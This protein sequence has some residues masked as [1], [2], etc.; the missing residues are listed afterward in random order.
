MLNELGVEVSPRAEFCVIRRAT[1]ATLKRI[2][3][4]EKFPMRFSGRTKVFLVMFRIDQISL[5]SR[6]RFFIETI[7]GFKKMLIFQAK[8]SNSMEGLYLLGNIV[9]IS[10]K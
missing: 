7:I 1:A 5:Y 2:I 8:S 6:L 9:K 4:I 3:H 10:E